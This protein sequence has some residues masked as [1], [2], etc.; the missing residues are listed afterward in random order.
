MPATSTPPPEPKY[1]DTWKGTVL[2]AIAVN[3]AE[4]YRELQT[5]T[6]LSDGALRVALKEL[7]KYGHIKKVPGMPITYQPTNPDLIQSYRDY[8]D[9]LAT[10]E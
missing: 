3:G 8:Y 7:T 10:K 9:Y 2:A 5:F 1:Y 4:T 6:R